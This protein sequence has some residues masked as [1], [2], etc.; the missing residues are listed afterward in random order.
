MNYRRGKNGL[1]RA[2]DKAKKEYHDSVCDKVT[3]FQRTGHNDLK[4]MKTKEQVW[5]ENYGI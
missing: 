3:E 2:T 4:Y 5:K 1:K